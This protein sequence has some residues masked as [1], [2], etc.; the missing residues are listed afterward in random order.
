MFAFEDGQLVSVDAIGCTK[1]LHYAPTGG[2]DVDLPLTPARTQDMVHPSK[3]KG[4]G[5]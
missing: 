4:T 2:D 5:L 1:H 3:G